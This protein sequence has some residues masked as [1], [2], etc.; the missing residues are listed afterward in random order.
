LRVQAHSDLGG[1]ELSVPLVAIL[2]GTYNGATFLREQLSSVAQQEHQNWILYVSD[3]GSTDH[4]RDIVGSFG[5]SGDVR[6]SLRT[7]PARG[8][9]T[10]FLSL[11]VDGSIEADYFAYCD[12]DDIWKPEK[13]RRAIAHLQTAPPGPSL[14]GSRVDLI[15]TEGRPRGRSPLFGRKPHFKNALVQNIVGGNTMVFNRA[16]K[17]LLERA[18]IVDVVAHDWWTYQ[19]ISAAGGTVLYDPETTVRY[20]QH[21]QN[22]IGSNV[23]W[24]PR[25]RRLQMLL[26]SRFHDWNT[27]NVKALEGC[28]DLI[29]PENRATLELFKSARQQP[30]AR[31]RLAVLRRAGVYRQTTL[32]NLGLFAGA[33]LGKI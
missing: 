23:G 8:S 9:T 17:L 25:L 2:L 26:S 10:N 1:K 21:G 12:Q 3:D 7:G 20:R 15:D 16:A 4:T 13:L 18:G 5:R 24:G 28:L 32:G 30:S 6:F 31:Q 29:T 19:L 11:A 22:L 33:A 14:Y 27:R